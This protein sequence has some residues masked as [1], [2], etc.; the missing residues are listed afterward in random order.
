MKKLLL[1]FI[2]IL[3]V[4]ALAACGNKVD[5]AT[6][7]HYISQ[8]VDVVKLLNEE[9]YENVVEQFDATMKASLTAAQLAELSPVIAA[10]GQFKKIQKQSIEEKNGIYVVVLVAKYQEGNHIYTVSFNDNNEI[11][12]LFV[13]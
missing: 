5:E 10:S 3:A 1:I 12:G 13:K 11:A 9:D 7:D 2:S 4:S 8:A 6:A